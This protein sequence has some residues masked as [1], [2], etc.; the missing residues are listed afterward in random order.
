MWILKV[1]F[2][3]PEKQPFRGAC[4]PV[5][6]HS[7]STRRPCGAS[8]NQ[9][10]RGN[11]KTEKRIRRHPPGKVSVINEH[12]PDGASILHLQPRNLLFALVNYF[13]AN[14]VLP[15]DFNAIHA[16][17][18]LDDKINLASLESFG[19]VLPV[20]RNHKSPKGI[21]M[22]F[23]I[24]MPLLDI[25]SHRIQ[26]PLVRTSRTAA[27]SISQSARKTAISRPPLQFL[28]ALMKPSAWWRTLDVVKKCW[29]CVK[30]QIGNAVLGASVVYA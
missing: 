21:K 2:N 8:P 28:S 25:V 7:K 23:V 24:F 18:R 20:I 4:P 17:P 19:L 30:R 10:V 12:W 11:N 27:A 29:G 13:F 14:R 5:F 22:T 6:H 15:L 16:L 9:I 1:P 3:P 26:R